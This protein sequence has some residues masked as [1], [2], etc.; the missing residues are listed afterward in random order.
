MPAFRVYKF[1]AGRTKCM[2]PMLKRTMWNNV[3]QSST[4]L[5]VNIQGVLQGV[6]KPYL[7][8]DLFD[9]RSSHSYK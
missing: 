1:S 4:V 8:L 7:R 9:P 2:S 5:I 6:L 3:E